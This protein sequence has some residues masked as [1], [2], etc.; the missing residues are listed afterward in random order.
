MEKFKSVL[1]SLNK[2]TFLI[3]FALITILS[4]M[5]FGGVNLLSHGKKGAEINTPEISAKVDNEVNAATS[6]LHANWQTRTS[7]TLANSK[8]ANIVFSNTLPDDTST[9]INVGATSSTYTGST[10]SGSVVAYITD[11][12]ITFYSQATIYA[13]ADSSYL[14]SN[15][16]ESARLTS[17]SSIDFGNFNTSEATNMDSMFC[18]CSALTSINFGD[19]FNTSNVRYMNNM[20]YGCNSLENLNLS[21]FNT[22]SVIDMQWMFISCSSL[23]KLD[24]SSFNTS[25]VTTMNCTFW[26][27]SALTEIIF[28]ND[29]DTSSVTNMGGMFQ[30]CRSLTKFNVSNFSTGQ[31]TDM[32]YMF[33]DCS[34]LTELDISSFTIGSSTIVTDMLTGCSSLSIIK[35]PVSCY[36][37]IDIPNGSWCAVDDDNSILGGPYTTLNSSNTNKTI[38]LVAFLHANWQTRTSGTLANS[39]IA[40]IVFSNTLPDDTSTAINVGATSSTYTGST[41]S[42]SVVAYITDN[43]I[44]FYSQATIYAPADSSYLFSNG[45]ESARLTSLSSIDFGNFNTSEATNMDSMFCG[46]SALTS[47]NF[48]DNFNTSNVRYMNN[49]FYG[50]NS[51]EN[52][53]LSGFNTSSVIDMQWMFISCSSLTKL[54]VSSFNTSNVTTMNCTFWGCSALTEIIFGNDFD[55]SSVTNMGGMFQS[56]RSL[57]KFN[58]S[59]FSTGQVTDME[60]MFFDCSDLT[61]LDISSFTIGSSTIVTDMLTG[62]TSLKTFVAPGSLGKALVLP[63]S[64]F[65]DTSLAVNAMVFTDTVSATDDGKTFKVGYV[66]TTNANGGT[67]SADASGDWTVADDNLTA[68]KTILWDEEIGN[69]P[70]PTQT[71]CTLAGWNEEQDGTGTTYTAE[72]KISSETTL[73]AQWQAVNYTITIDANGGSYGGGTSNTTITKA[74]GYT[75]TLE[76][77]TRAGYSFAGWTL[78]G[79]GSL[80]GTTYTFGAS[81]CT[82]T[83]NWTAIDYT[84]TIDANDGS[85]GLVSPSTYNISENSQTATITLPTRDGYLVK[86]WTISGN[87]SATIDETLTILTIPAETYGNITL[88][89]NWVLDG[90]GVTISVNPNGGINGQNLVDLNSINYDW[91]GSNGHNMK[92]SY[93]ASSGVYTLTPSSTDDPYATAATTAYLTAG[94]TYYIYYK[95]TNSSGVSVADNKMQIYYAIN[96]GFTEVQSVRS[97]SNGYS[98]FTVPTTGTYNFRFD[99]DYDGQTLLVSQFYITTMSSQDSYEFIIGSGQ[100]VQLGVPSKSG[101]TFK[102]WSVNKIGLSGSADGSVNSNNVLTIGSHDLTLTANWV[103]AGADITVSV[104]P[105]GG[106]NGQ[107][108]VELSSINYDWIGSYSQNMTMSYNASSGVYTLT[109]SGLFDPYATAATT[110][111]LTAGVTYYMYY[112]VTDSSGASVADDKMQ[113]FYAINIGYRPD[114]SVR[115]NSNG[116]NQFTVPTTG[117]YNF[118]FDND[119]DGQTLLVSQFYITTMS[120]QDNYEF[121]LGSGQS[122]QLGV[123]SKSGHTFIGWSVD[124]AGSSVD[125]NNV[126]TIGSTNVTLTAQWTANT[127]TIAFDGNGSTSGSTASVTAIYDTSATLTANGFTKNGYNFLGWATTATGSVAY[128]NGATLTATQVNLIYNTEGVGNGGT[129]T[130]Y[131]QWQIIIFNITIDANGGRDSSVSPETYSISSS[132]QTATITLP[133]KDGYL[134]MDWAISGYTGTKPTIDGTT[135][136]IPANTFGNILLTA[137]WELESVITVT[138]TSSF[139]TSAEA[140]AVA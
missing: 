90:A 62:M 99:N 10:F 85:G 120:S 137:V 95:V 33:F 22:S 35:T 135:L 82:L 29:F 129:Y 105:N 37:T 114:Q 136:T 18:G 134:F 81:D 59:N 8:I 122:V 131:A 26:G 6:Y 66:L 126:L 73:Y 108:M 79:G 98:Q 48:G 7:G 50:C 30:S 4:A 3:L 94:V 78:S 34:D 92:L 16:T 14:F 123:P 67:L 132:S 39:K 57:T 13:P 106:I 86:N 42:G 101:H 77:P 87:I 117:T 128:E 70:T 61:E 5:F 125:S 139:E 89:S 43:A 36:T 40:N 127:Y 130:L 109:P 107:N 60:Y 21:G 111:Y 63:N 27:C 24:V 110:A 74:N 100:S 54:D 91:T 138:I 75:Y 104:N 51:L 41:F 31:V 115:N 133:T 112:K 25:N 118:R 47:I 49:M 113:I 17:L 69:W 56:C 46:C 80:N 2:K 53:N 76:A 121:I 44:T 32:E 93:N 88:T 1:N 72:S 58:V 12:A 19:N 84:I 11:N 15:G 45:T 38:K 140:G 124:G 83:A 119:Y 9:A 68:T 28:G 23:T 102:G 103:L 65:V 71:D 55:T 20:F 97:N 52:L 96:N 116:Y 64:N